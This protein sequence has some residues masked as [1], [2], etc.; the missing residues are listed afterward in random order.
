[1]ATTC[2]HCG[3]TTDNDSRVMCPSCGRRMQPPGASPATESTSTPAPDVGAPPPSPYAPPPPPYGAPPPPPYGAPPPPPYA[4]APPYASGYAYDAGLPPQVDVY[5][6]RDAIARTSRVTVLFRLV[7]VLPHLIALAF[8]ALA[9][10]LLT[11]VTWFAALFTAR[12]PAALYEVLA[13]TVSYGTRVMAYLFFLTDRWPAFSER[14]DEPVVVRMPGPGRLNRAA[15]LFRIVLLIPVGFLAEFVNN[16]LTLVSIVGWLLILVMGRVPQSLF[17]ATASAVRYQARYLAYAIMLTARYPGG[18]F[19]DDGSPSE[20]P[21][22]AAGQSPVP[23]VM[24]RPAKRIV[25]AFIVLGVLASIARGVNSAENNG[26]S[27]SG[28]HLTRAGSVQLP[29]ATAVG[30]EPHDVVRR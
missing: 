27:Y 1:M 19:G 25:V 9:A 5:F 18:L 6:R 20:P 29:E 2:Q 22:V 26:P 30:R 17:D 4:A 12:V 7:L 8:V 13:W 14:P 24:N 21:P 10:A 16:G 3:A 15:V 23:P 28:L 11:V